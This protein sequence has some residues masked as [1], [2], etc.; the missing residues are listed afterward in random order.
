MATSKSR[1]VQTRTVQ[2]R[3]ARVGPAEAA[4]EAA[5]E[6]ARRDRV[7]A[8]LVEAHGLPQLGRP[9]PV[10]RR[11]E[12]LARSIVYQQLAGR[13]AAA[14][15]ARFVAEVGGEVTAE[16][17][18]ERPTASLRAC[19]LSAAKT[20]AIVDLASRSASGQLSLSRIGRLAD[21]EVVAHLVQV[22]GVGVWTAHMFL[23]GTLG[24]LDVWPVGDY[25][26]RAGFARAWRLPEMP[27]PKALMDHG[28]AFRPYRSV[29][30]WYCWRVVDQR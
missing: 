8:D 30:A 3:T 6:L 28:E 19:G 16:S 13:A 5:A 10:A 2:T 7:V 12:A 9:A 29:V 4:A 1:T 24:R 23:L 20:A 18:L 11:F 17:V 14:I 25:G 21:D 27:S 22:K 15:H 26:V